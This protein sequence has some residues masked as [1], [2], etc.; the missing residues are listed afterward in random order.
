MGRV[1]FDEMLP[2]GNPLH[3]VKLDPAI[4]AGSSDTVISE[5]AI[6]AMYKYWRQEMN[7]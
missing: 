7:I 2:V 1:K 5:S 4:A 3:A 6:R